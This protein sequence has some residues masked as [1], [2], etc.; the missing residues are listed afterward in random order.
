MTYRAAA[1]GGFS[2]PPPVPKRTISELNSLRGTRLLASFG[3]SAP[4]AARAGNSWRDVAAPGD[5]GIRR[6]RLVIL[7]LASQ[8]IWTC[9]LLVVGIPTVIAMILT[10]FVRSNV[11]FERL[12]SNNEVAGFKFAVVSMVYAVL[13]GFAIITVWEKFKDAEDA[14]TAEAASTA[15]IYRLADE[16][17]STYRPALQAGVRHYL[18]SVLGRE[19]DTIV[20][21][22][23]VSTTIALNNLYTSVLA[24]KPTNA[25]ES[26]MFSATLDD[27]RLLAEARRERL[28]LSR[29]AAP[30]ILWSVLV[31]GAILNIAF[32]LF[33]GTKHVMSRSS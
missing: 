25:K 30:P 26:D 17:E 1:S 31:G 20:A 6:D 13:L 16:F 29:G 15:G 21:S 22:F 14:V 12:V 11:G 3:H 33:F 10:V 8:P 32:A 5:R 9:A 27:L 24:A 28:E 7:W 23:D 18:T 19:A 2:E 4:Q